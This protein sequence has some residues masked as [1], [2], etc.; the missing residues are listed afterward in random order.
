M[1]R[2]ENPGIF[3]PSQLTAIKQS[4]LARVICD[5]TDSIKSLPRDVFLIQSM[6]DFVSC[7]EVPSIDLSAWID[8]C[9]DCSDSGSFETLSSKWACV[10]YF[11]VFF[12]LPSE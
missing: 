7:D 6:S 2:Y 11:F 12:C 3:T 5:N 1:F 9:S 10:Y 8:C 4:S